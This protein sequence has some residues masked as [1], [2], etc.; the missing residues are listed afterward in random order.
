MY[1]GFKVTIFF[2]FI[3]HIYTYDKCSWSSA[4]NFKYPYWDDENLARFTNVLKAFNEA[5]ITYFVLEGALIGAYR[6]G[7]PVPCDGDLDIV[8]PVWLNH[9]LADCKDTTMPFLRGYVININEDLLTLCGKNRDQWVDITKPWLEKRIHHASF[10]K[11]DFGGFKVHMANSVTTDLMSSML[12]HHYMNHGPICKC[13]FAD[14][15]TFCLEDSLSVLKKIYG[16]S[17]MIPDKKVLRCL[18]T[19][20]TKWQKHKVEF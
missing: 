10:Y 16:D 2:L 5:N 8:V 3:K 18:K 7:G 9:E 12:D 11:S 1:N 14:V 6:H 19:K 17:V 15:E 13:M 4:E 20:K